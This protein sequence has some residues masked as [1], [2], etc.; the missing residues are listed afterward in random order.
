MEDIFQKRECESSNLFKYCPKALNRLLVDIVDMVIIVLDKDLKIQ[1]YNKAFANMLIYSTEKIE[2]LNLSEL[3]KKETKLELPLVGGMRKQNLKFKSEVIAQE[4]WMGFPF[5]CYIINEDDW[6]LIAGRHEL[7][8]REEY[9]K[10][11]T[12]LN[13]QMSNKTRELTQKNIELKRTRAKI[14]KLLRTDELTGISNRRA[15]IEFFKKIFSLAKRHAYSLSLVTIDLDNFKEI[16]DSFGHKAGDEVLEKVGKLLADN[17]RQEDMAARIG[18][19]EFSVLLPETTQEKAVEF[20]RRLKSKIEQIDLDGI[21]HELSASFGVAEL[22]TEE[23][24]DEFLQ[25]A[26]RNLYKAKKAGKNKITFNNKKTRKDE[27]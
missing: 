24:M 1:K 16:N 2:G 20:A 6:Y 4:K 13:N 27:K 9:F 7:P 11:L 14:E 19:D 10:E 25:R 5:N 22:G 8:E 18:G 3:L 17:I 12:K 15:F 26:D 21:S 23:S